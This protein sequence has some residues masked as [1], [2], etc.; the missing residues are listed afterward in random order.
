V[1]KGGDEGSTAG[2]SAGSDDDE[3]QEADGA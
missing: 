1:T 2:P 3:G